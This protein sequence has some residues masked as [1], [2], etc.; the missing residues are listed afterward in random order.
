MEIGEPLGNS[1]HNMIRF[2]IKLEYRNK[3]NLKKVPNFRVADFEGL[4]TRLT[5]V[6]WDRLT[7]EEDNLSGQA[8]LGSP[9]GTRLPQGEANNSNYSGNNPP[10]LPTISR[11]VDDQY[12][13]FVNTLKNIQSDYIPEKQF[14]SRNNDPKWMNCRIKHMIGIKRG[15]YKRLKRGEQHLRQQYIQLNRDVKKKIRESKRNYEI[16]IAREAKQNPKGFYQQYQTKTKERVGPIEVENGHI[17]DDDK[18]M[19][20][21]LNEYFLSVFTSE[22]L[23]YIPEIEAIYSGNSENI[24]RTIDISREDVLKELNKLKSHKSPGPDE[25]YARVLKECKAELCCPLV[26]LFNN[27]IKSGIV[28]KAW[29][30]ADVVP[31]FKKGEKI[32]KSNYRPISLTSTVGKILESIIANKIGEHLEKHKFIKLSQHG[33]LNGFSCLTNL[34]SFYSE[35][36]KAVDSGKE[37]DTVYLDFSKAFDKVP[38]ERLIRKVEAHGI[39]GN[40][41]RWIREWLRDR[42]QR[43]CINGEKSDW[44]DVT[45][46]VPQG[47]VLGPLLFIIYIN[48]L[49]VNITSNLSKFADD[50]KIGRTTNDID[51]SQAL[52]DDLNKLYDWSVKWQME[53]NVDKCKVMRMGTVSHNISYQLNDKEIGTTQCER[54]L[55][56]RV[57]KD[58]KPKEQVISV[59]NKANRILGF[60]SR[61]VSNRS[62]EVILKLYLAL[63]R[64]HLDYAV[65]FWS[66]YYRKDIDPL[67]RIQRR[68]TKMIHSIRNLSYMDRLKKLNLHSLERRRVRGDMIEVYKWFNGINKGDINRV[69]KLNNLGRTRSNGFKLDKTRFR[70]EIGRNWFGNRVVDTWN[71]LPRNVVN[72]KTLNIFKN[73]LDNHMTDDG[74]V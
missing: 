39:G 46:G 74:W 56:V 16:K 49:D 59:R 7:V 3:D 52:Q 24:L 45:S 32:K 50:T 2:D 68:M 65:Q 71:A 6:E 51:D 38:H 44:G 55:G 63:V 23:E 48:D 4:K 64:P 67:E 72:A 31:I 34:L 29:K 27:S 30:L 10:G 28:P 12:N 15:I 53:F 1:D 26:S 25:V 73:R 22:N 43:V 60:I 47:S 11:N 5:E 37:Y 20:T 18:R 66:P 61:S 14:R 17:T 62:E 69:L 19:C 58:L 13:S 41:L 35:A 9:L 70:K 8:G 33:F 54:D 36:Y 57:N 40:V 42:K 21:C